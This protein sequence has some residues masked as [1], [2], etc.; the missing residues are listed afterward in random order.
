MIFNKLQNKN[1][2][3]HRCN[4]ITRCTAFRI[5]GSTCP[6]VHK[7]NQQKKNNLIPPTRRST[8][9]MLK[10][11][12]TLYDCV[13]SAT[14]KYKFIQGM[15]LFNQCQPYTY[16]NINI[17]PFRFS[18]GLLGKKKQAKAKKPLNQNT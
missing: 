13:E 3:F 14:A 12:H 6:T 4:K 15:F 7:S 2:P 16:R 17:K 11:I 10:I 5:K 9:R 8:I 1:K 18:D